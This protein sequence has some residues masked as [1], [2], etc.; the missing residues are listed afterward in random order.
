MC[1]QGEEGEEEKEEKC[2]LRLEVAQK[3]NQGQGM[4]PPPSQSGAAGHPHSTSHGNYSSWCMCTHSHLT[5]AERAHACVL[6]LLSLDATVVC[7]L[8]PTPVMAPMARLTHD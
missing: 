8:V 2:S 5:E 4:Q 7:K 1:R 3:N 6:R